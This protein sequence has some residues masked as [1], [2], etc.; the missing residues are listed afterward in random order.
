MAEAIRA[1]TGYDVVAMTS[2]EALEA[3]TDLPPCDIAL[4]D[5]S[6]PGSGKT[7][8]DALLILH[9]RSPGTALVVLTQG[10]DWVADLLR[11]AWEA[12]PL[13]SVL[14]KTVPMATVVS[15]LERVAATGSA[16]IDPVLQPLLPATRSPW[17]S[18]DGYGRLV[19][20]LG[21]AKL[22]KALIEAEGEPSYRDLA[23][24]TGLS[25]NTIRNYREQLLGELA[26]HGLRNPTMRDM[27]A[28]ARRCRPLLEPHIR[29]RVERRS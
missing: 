27:K 29:A 3:A 14:S 19:Q 13:A 4:V 16:P 6:F 28:F 22:W 17:R 26:L 10:D 2:V 21:H 11:D 12:L 18:L 1:R 23:E 15:T 7:G 5:L 9:E 8:L 25:M 24:A 20:H